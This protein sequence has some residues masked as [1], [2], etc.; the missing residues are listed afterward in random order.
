MS[1]AL[2]NIFYKYVARRNSTWMAGAI[3]GA[4]VL[5]STVSGAVNTFFDSVNKGKLWKDV[6]A[7]RVKKGISQ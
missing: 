7:E 4:F 3:L 1:N 2:T 6:Y 5:D